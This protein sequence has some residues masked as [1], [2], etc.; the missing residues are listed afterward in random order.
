M[1]IIEG[2][3]HDVIHKITPD[4]L[5]GF[6]SNNTEHVQTWKCFKIYSSSCSNYIPNSGELL[7][8]KRNMYQIMI[9]K[10]SINIYAN[11]HSLDILDRNV[12]HMTDGKYMHKLMFK[13]EIVPYLISIQS[14]P[15]LVNC[16]GLR[17]RKPITKK[18]IIMSMPP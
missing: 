3:L 10:S 15:K 17:Y 6:L 4:E 5:F 18:S 1:A 8:Y 12:N 9:T 2:A 11:S 16:R 13:L 14:I 7:I